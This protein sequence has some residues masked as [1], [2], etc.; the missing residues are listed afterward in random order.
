MNSIRTIRFSRSLVAAFAV[1]LV[2]ASGCGK[3]GPGEQ[4]GASDD[5]LRA[6]K[7]HGGTPGAVGTAAPSYAL[8]DLE[9]KVVKNTD[10]L[11]KVV[12]LDFWA[13][14]CPPCKAEIPHLVALQDKYK[15]QGLEIVGLSVDEG[16]ANDVKP[17][18]AEHQINYTMLIASSETAKDYGGIT[19]IPTTFVVDKQGTIVK[20]FLGYT[21][22][23]V[24]EAAI[25]PLLAAN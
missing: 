4:G 20:K 23:E 21:D 12:I 5:G 16:G 1:A 10:F 6:T 7:G 15:S 13:T 2:L 3:R 24:F 9:G 17:F 14:W 22:P 11:G 8:A 18:A 25:Q 19:G